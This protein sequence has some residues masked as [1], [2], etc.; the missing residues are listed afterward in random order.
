VK[1]KQIVIG[2][3]ASG[4]QAIYGLGEDNKVYIWEYGDGGNWK[5]NFDE[6]SST[7]VSIDLT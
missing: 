3:S 5:A 1:I 2:K 4:S 7:D 6:N